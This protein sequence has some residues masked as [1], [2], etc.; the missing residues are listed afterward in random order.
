MDNLLALSE[1][2]DDDLVPEILPSSASLSF[3]APVAQLRTVFARAAAVAPSKEVVPG[4]AHALLEAIPMSKTQLA[5]VRLTASDGDQ[6]VSVV[7]DSG[8]YVKTPGSVLLPPKR[9]LDILKLAPADKVSV[10][11]VGDTA[12]IRSGRARWSVQTP[13]GDVVDL[14]RLADLSLVRMTEVQVQPFLKALKAAR[15][16]ASTS[17]ARVSLMQVMIKDSTITACDGGRLHKAE[18]PDFDPFLS[19]TIPLRAVDEVIRAMNETSEPSLSVGSTDKFLV[20]RIGSDSIVAQRLI[21]P[22]P[23]IQELFLR[24]QVANQLKLVVDRL[25]LL[26]A[27]Q[28]VRINSDP[29]IALVTLSTVRGPLGRND[30]ILEVKS[31]DRAGNTAQETLDCQW[32]GKAKE[33]AFNHHHLTDLLSVCTSEFLT[34]RMSD[35]TRSTR[36][37]LL[38][39]DTEAGF[40]GV[41]QQVTQH[42]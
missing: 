41:V 40:E 9:V 37:P 39:E 4:T 24:P 26:H 3:G 10:D 36:S 15:V 42:W 16:A 29:D 38:V 35:D 30:W 18:I 25:E 11:V 2:E 28:R 8:V 22:F 13:V 14:G 20:F 5:H 7:F 31:R 32:S 33:A 17:N 27:V 6:T 12:L 1:I 21:L 34:L 19:T 23:D